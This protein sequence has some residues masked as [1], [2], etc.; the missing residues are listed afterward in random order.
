M[1]D[2]GGI[3]KHTIADAS[4]LSVCYNATDKAA[5]Y[6]ACAGS[7]MHRCLNCSCEC[8]FG[9]RGRRCTNERCRNATL[10]VRFDSWRFFQSRFV[11]NGCRILST[12]TETHFCVQT[13]AHDNK[14]VNTHFPFPCSSGPTSVVVRCSVHTSQHGVPISLRPNSLFGPS[15]SLFFSSLLLH[16]LPRCPHGCL[17]MKKE[18]PFI[19]LSNNAI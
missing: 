15:Q 10:L 1:K 3:R 7:H 17:T 12:N 5:A 13:K 4:R 2:S 16:S 6:G 8:P 11:Q 9:R 14:V 18:M 19:H